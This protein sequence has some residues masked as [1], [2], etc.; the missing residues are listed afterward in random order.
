VPQ[1]DGGPVVDIAY[2]QGDVVWVEPDGGQ[3]DEGDQV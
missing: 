1:P 2:D 3:A